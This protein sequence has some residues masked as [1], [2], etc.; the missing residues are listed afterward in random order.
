MKN[1]TQSLVEIIQSTFK[2]AKLNKFNKSLDILTASVEQGT[3]LLRG[4]A[5]VYAG[6]NMGLLKANYNRRDYGDSPEAEKQS[7]AWDL[8]FSL[9]HG[10]AFKGDLALAISVLRTG[11][12]SAGEA[13]K[14]KVS[15]E[16]IDAWVKLIDELTEIAAALDEARPLPRVTPIGLSEK[17][18]VTLKE[19]NL[20]IDLPSIKPAKIV[21]K[22]RPSYCL[23]TGKA[24]IDNEGNQL[25]EKYHEVAWTDGILHNQSRF[26]YGCQACG[27]TIPS[28][29]FVPIE[30]IDKNN[31]GR[32]ISM[33]LGCDCAS[34]IFGVKDIGLART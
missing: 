4:K 22:T 8:A 13:L 26:S 17:V 21:T 14:I 15:D 30:A 3:W 19:M 31:G 24:L 1:L 9:N 32:L 33:W 27:K 23:T 16:A 6:F 2:G 20:D 29:R 7:L 11:A 5:S 10:H 12:N 18:T 28:G 25:M 34:N